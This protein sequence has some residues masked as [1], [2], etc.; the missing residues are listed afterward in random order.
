MSSIL[1]YG[2]SCKT[3]LDESYSTY[4]KLVENSNIIYKKIKDHL[5]VTQLTGNATESDSSDAESPRRSLFNAFKWGVP[6]QKLFLQLPTQELTVQ[7]LH[8]HNDTINDFINIKND[9]EN[10][11]INIENNI[12][13]DNIDIENNNIKNNNI[14]NNDIEMAKKLTSVSFIK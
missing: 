12:K 5:T 9:I 1:M 14:E 13:N 8:D 4:V 2:I 7:K 6:L 10:N 11:N 3:F